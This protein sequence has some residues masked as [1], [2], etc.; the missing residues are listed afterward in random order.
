MKVFRQNAGTVELLMVD[1]VLPGRNGRDLAH[2][3]LRSH[4]HLKIVFVSGYP[5]NAV[6]RNADLEHKVIY[7]PKPFS[8]ASLMRKVREAIVA[9]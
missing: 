5:E 9:T 3:L 7:L 6:T 8:V 1:V 2:D 4:P